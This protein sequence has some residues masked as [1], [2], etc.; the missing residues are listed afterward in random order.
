MKTLEAAVATQVTKIID[1]PT[2]WPSR[3]RQSSCDSRSS[4]T[5][6]RVRSRREWNVSEIYR[7]TLT[8]C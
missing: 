3:M 8:A 5:T 6:D 4:A 2:D 7:S 1:R